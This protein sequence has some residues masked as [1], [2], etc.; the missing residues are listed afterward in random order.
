MTQAKDW[1]VVSRS[2]VVSPF[3]ATEGEAYVWA[4]ENGF[5]DRCAHLFAGVEVHR[6]PAIDIDAIY[7]KPQRPTGRNVH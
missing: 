5:A 1:A 4:S 7:H 3:F 6:I 2:L